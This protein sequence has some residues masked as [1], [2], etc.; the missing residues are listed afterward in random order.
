MKQLG[1][2]LKTSI[3]STKFYELNKNING[4]IFDITNRL[5]NV[6]T[7]LISLSNNIRNKP[8]DKNTNICISFQRKLANDLKQAIIE[9]SKIKEEIKNEAYN[10]FRYQYIISK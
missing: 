8:K 4:L 1:T 10:M 9:F 3:N 6:G 7:Q 2:E 5:Q